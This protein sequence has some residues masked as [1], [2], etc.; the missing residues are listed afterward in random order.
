MCCIVY[1]DVSR[2][3]NS[4]PNLLTAKSR[5]APKEMSIPRLEFIAAH[6]LAKLQSN[7][8]RALASFPITAHHNWVDS[9]TGYYVGWQIV[10]SGPLPYVTE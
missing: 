4:G 10:E 8:S 9:V 3:D 7:A 5:V 2:L 6:T 1:C